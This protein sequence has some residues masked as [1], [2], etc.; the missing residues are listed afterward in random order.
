MRMDMARTGLPYSDQRGQPL[1]RKAGGTDQTGK[2]TRR[3]RIPIN[4]TDDHR[5]RNPRK[6]MTVT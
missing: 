6:L 3:R 1:V 2:K 4:I 5:A